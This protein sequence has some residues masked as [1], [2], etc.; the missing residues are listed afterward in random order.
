MRERGGKNGPQFLTF[1]SQAVGVF[2]R[3]LDDR[4]NSRLQVEVSKKG[5]KVNKKEEKSE[6]CQL[7]VAQRRMQNVWCSD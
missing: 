2:I 7:H 6:S 4:D 5:E 3:F 1:A